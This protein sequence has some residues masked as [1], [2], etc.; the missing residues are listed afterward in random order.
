MVLALTCKAVGAVQVTGVGH[1]QAKRLDHVAGALLERAGHGGE[2]V[3]G[4]ELAHLLERLHVADAQAD[5]FLGH[6]LAIAIFGHHGA[7]DFLR[8]GVFIHGDDI[9][10]DLVHAVHAA[11]AGVQHDVI[12]VKFV[13]VQHD[14][15]PK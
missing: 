13:L 9:V 8:R 5:F 1:V 4:E 12:A 11:G 6:V 2:G 3:R 14:I 7:D 10:G 15:P